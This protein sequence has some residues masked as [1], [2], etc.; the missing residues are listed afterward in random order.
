MKAEIRGS[1]IKIYDCFHF[2][3]SIKAIEGRRFAPTRTVWFVPL[4][5]ANIALL[6][7]LGAEFDESADMPNDT[8]RVIS[9]EPAIV[10]MPI[11]ATPYKHQIAAFNFA[12]RVFGTAV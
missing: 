8:G 4:S 12:L 1:E 5:D 7:M 3:E 9:D 6:K 11:K 2:K 10:G